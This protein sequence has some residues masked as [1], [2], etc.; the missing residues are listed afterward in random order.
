MAGVI[1]T[2]SFAKALWP[3]VKTWFGMEY[4]EHPPEYPKIFKKD[5]SDKAYEEMVATSG[6][7][8]APVKTETGSVSY[9]SMRQL[10]VNRATHV[11][12]ALGFIIS[13]VAIEDNQYKQL[14]K[15]RSRSLAFSLRQTKETVA[16]NVLNRAFNSTYTGG[17][18]LE[19]CS[20]A[21][22]TEGSTFA[23]E[24]A[25]AADL[26]GASLEQA[27]IDI[28]GFV[29]HRNL[30]INV[31]PQAL[32]VHRNNMFE[33]ERILKSA[34]EYDTANNAINALKSMNM[35]PKGIIVNHYLTDADAF[36]VLTDATDG[37]TFFQRRPLRLSPVE[38]DYDT[39]NAKFKADERYS[40]TWGDPRSIF[41][42]PGA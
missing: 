41:G 31:M 8:L 33:A 7:G 9:D 36:F 32:L 23:N 3:G 15:Q 37:M 10:Y 14:A 24:L 20:T 28:A 6:T 30:N 16:A 2:G 12:Y 25:T 40:F 42:S 5:T 21:H 18:G 22:I 13:E 34:L 35:F 11:E 4:K 27:V 19:L 26:S 1:N 38:N 17:D 29:N 39:A